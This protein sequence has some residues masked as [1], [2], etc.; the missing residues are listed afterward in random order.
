M[1]VGRGLPRCLKKSGCKRNA[2]WELFVEIGGL[3]GNVGKI[4]HEYSVISGGYLAVCA[5]LTAVV[6][7]DTQKTPRG[8]E[9]YATG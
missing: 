6:G 7:C 4:P 5:V 3:V 1:R 2:D 8:D 9:F